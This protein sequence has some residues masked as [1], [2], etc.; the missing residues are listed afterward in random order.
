MSQN[1]MRLKWSRKEVDERLHQIMR[2]IFEKCRKA[3]KEFG[4]DEKDLIAGAN[5]AGFRKVADAFIA[6]GFV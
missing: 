1:A 5:V 2:E 4:K 6:E 3:A